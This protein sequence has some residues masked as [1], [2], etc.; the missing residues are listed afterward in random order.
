VHEVVTRSETS[1]AGP[2]ARGLPSIHVLYLPQDTGWAHN[3]ARRSYDALTWLGGRMSPYPYPQFTNLHRFEGGGTEFPM[4]IMDGGPGEGLIVHETGHQWVH[5]ILGNNEWK[6][7]WLDEGFTSF[8]TNWYWEEKYHRM[9]NDTT[10]V[11]R[12]TMAT[13]E[14][15]EHA[16]S[17]QPIAWPSERFRDF[18]TYN[19]MT[20]TKPSAVL[21]MLREYLGRDVTERVLHEYSRRYQFRHVTGE[22]LRHVAEQVSGKDLGWFWEEWIRTTA[23]LDYAVTSAKTRHIPGGRWRTTVEISRDGE[24]W[25]PVDLQVGS[26]TRHLVTRDRT[27]RVVVDTAERPAEAVVD[28][29]WILIDSNRANNRMPVQ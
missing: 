27:Q 2:E 10:D 17:A 14:R 28:P 3:A 16:D 23:R 7:G 5:G 13:L 15:L 24:A 12:G 22:D 29:K 1:D 21:R 25:M 19:L 4:L 11:W 18:R 6:E 26:E 9:G 8:L 20:Y